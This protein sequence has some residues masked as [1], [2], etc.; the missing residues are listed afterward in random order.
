MLR[1]A[2]ITRIIASNFEHNGVALKRIITCEL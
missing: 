1:S 2:T